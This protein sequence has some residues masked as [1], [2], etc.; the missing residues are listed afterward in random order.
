M[1][2]LKHIFF[3]TKEISEYCKIPIREIG[4]YV[5]KYG[6]PAFKDSG[7]EK[8]PW[9]ARPASLELWAEEHEK[10]FLKRA[11]QYENK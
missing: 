11:C 5:E 8:A 6:L 7:S 3:S 2:A 1:E 9:K 4:K 10:R